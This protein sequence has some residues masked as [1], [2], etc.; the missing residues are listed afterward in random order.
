MGKIGFPETSVDN[1]QSTPRHI[2]EEQKFHVLFKGY[3]SGVSEVYTT[4]TE[5][6]WKAA[7]RHFCLY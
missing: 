4:G 1:Y 5:Q 2:P 6:Q 3:I 7:M